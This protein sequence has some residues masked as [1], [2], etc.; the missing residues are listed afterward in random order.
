MALIRN[1]DATR[2]RVQRD[3]EFARLWHETAIDL[4]DGN[5]EDR[6]IALR[7]LRDHFGL[8]D[9]EID[10]LKRNQATA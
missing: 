7:I 4:L 6:R 3:P 1:D 10:E 5:N 8:T 9:A 2:A